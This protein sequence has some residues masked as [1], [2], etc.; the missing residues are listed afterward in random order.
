M[1]FENS[2]ALGTVA[3]WTDCNLSVSTNKC[4]E[5]VV[6]VGY[7]SII[8]LLGMDMVIVRLALVDLNGW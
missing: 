1:A 7:K 8:D 3:T 6:V 2:T 4:K 5:T